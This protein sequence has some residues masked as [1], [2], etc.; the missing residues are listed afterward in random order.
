[1]LIEFFF[2]FVLFYSLSTL[3]GI[4]QKVKKIWICMNFF[5]FFEENIALTIFLEVAMIFTDT[6]LT[7]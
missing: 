3:C 6:N 1:M 5:F 4:Y 2:V 7:T